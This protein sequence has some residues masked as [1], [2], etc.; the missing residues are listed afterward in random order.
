MR[1]LGGF[2]NNDPDE[3]TVPAEEIPKALL[4]CPS[5]CSG[6]KA[7]AGLSS[8]TPAVSPNA[9]RASW[10][11]ASGDIAAPDFFF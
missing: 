10:K 5:C 4:C 2:K 3:I 1:C 7:A 8:G 9:L 6:T 11:V